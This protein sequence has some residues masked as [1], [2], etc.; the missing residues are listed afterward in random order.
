MPLTDYKPE[1]P[2]RSN[3]IILTSNRVVLHSKSDSIFLFGKQA[4]SVSTNG[5]FNIDTAKGI[6]MA[7]P[8][9]ELGIEAKKVGHPL[10]KTKEFIEQLDRLLSQIATF[11]EAIGQ[12]RS[13]SIDLAAAMPLIAIQADFLKS[14]AEDVKLKIPGTYSNI[15]YTL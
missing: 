8:A 3:Q 6:T 13:N 10:I 2:Y 15:T 4:V 1:F 14:V 9:I 5:S 12:L 7:A 11:A